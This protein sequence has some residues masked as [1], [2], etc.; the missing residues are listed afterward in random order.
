M[1]FFKLKEKY[2]SPVFYR[3]CFFIYFSLTCS[4]INAQH[5]DYTRSVQNIIISGRK[6]SVLNL[7]PEIDSFYTK[8]GRR[9]V[10]RDL[11]RDVNTLYLTGYFKEVAA[12]THPTGNGL[13]LDFQVKENPLINN[14]FI[15]GNI[16]FSD[17]YLAGLMQNKKGDIFNIGKLK[18]D[19]EQI[20]KLYYE[21]GYELFKIDNVNL[22]AENN[23]RYFVTECLV[24]DITIKGLKSLD[25]NIVIREMRL[26][27][28]SVFNSYDLKEDREKLL[29]LGYFSDVFLPELEQSL[30]E[31]KVRMVYRVTEKKVNLFDLGFEQEED[32]I[33]GFLKSDYNHLLQQSDVVSGKLQ[34][35]SE[36]EVIKP[37]S[38]T[39]R[40]RQP[41]ILNIIPVSF[42][43]DFWKEFKREYKTEDYLRKN[44]LDTER[45]GWDCA[46]GFPLLKD[47]LIMSTRYKSE[48]VLSVNDSFDRYEINSISWVLRYQSVY[49]WNNPK[50][51]TYW[52]VEIEKGGRI[53]GVDLGGLDF[54]RYNVNLAT[55]FGFSQN[56][57][58]GINAFMGVFR[59]DDSNISTFEIEG[60]EIGGASSLRGYKEIAP[61]RDIRKILF[62][63]EYRYDFSKS[64]QGV[65]FVDLGKVFADGWNY[66]PNTFKKSAGFG[67]RFFTPVGPVRTDFA[68]G[69]SV[70]I[71]FGLGQVF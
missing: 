12:F 16:I 49:N 62:N 44:I 57:V 65:I 17:S 54:N 68:F 64:F 45:L 71:H 26:Q 59:P 42:T 67:F 1:R 56:A 11:A 46:L 18:E 51:G 5:I 32:I 4:I 9:V 36:G 43:V 31:K 40:Y 25:N 61:F 60:Y 24:E 21:K 19:R 66:E 55:F 48:D 70:M 53:G 37:R 50:K 33:V 13:V 63:V 7:L 41:W 58:L 27:K 47:R 38:Y 52:T 34:I 6:N 2:K 3:V 14:I 29:K 15:D 28:G 10:A 23:V 69:E 22:D 39:L 30:D 35:S 8:K 20:E